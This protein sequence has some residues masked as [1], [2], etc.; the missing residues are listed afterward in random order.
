MR[1]DDKRTV[2]IGLLSPLKLEAEFRN[3]HICGKIASI[4]TVKLIKPVVTEP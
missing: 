1:E 4:Y 2:K 3:E